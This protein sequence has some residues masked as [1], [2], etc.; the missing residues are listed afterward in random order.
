MIEVTCNWCKEEMTLM[1]RRGYSELFV[2]HVGAGPR[3]GTRL[4]LEAEIPEEKDM[5]RD[6]VKKEFLKAINEEKQ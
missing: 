5:C 4:C 2:L 3:T 6:C 1:P